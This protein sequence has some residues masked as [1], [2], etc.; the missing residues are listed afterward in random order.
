[1]DGR[2]VTG[3]FALGGAVRLEE[4]EGDPY[5]LLARLRAREPVSWVPALD[6]WLVT[7]HDLAMRVTRDPQTFTVDDPRFSTGQVVGPS[8]L[9]RDGEEH[10]RHRAPFVGPFRR[11]EVHARFAQLVTTQTEQLIDELQPAG[12]AE[13]RRGLAARLAV[14]VVTRALGIEDPDAKAVLR[15]YE[16]IVA[17]VTDLTAGRPI[18]VEGRDAYAALSAA[19]APALERDPD[20][21][22]LAAAAGD[23]GGLERERV[24]SN[25]AVL[26]FGGIETTEGMIANAVWH[27]LLHPDELARVTANHDLLTNAIEESLRLEP[28]AAIVDRYA[29]ADIELAGAPIRCGDLVRV[30][31]TAANRDPELFTDP[32]RFDVT[33]SNARRHLSFAHGPHACIAMH[34]ARL[35]TH[36]ALQRL[37]SRLPT[38][39]LDPARPAKPRGLVFRKPPEL[40]VLWTPQSTSRAGRRV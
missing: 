2:G 20:A 12:R 10:R 19:I 25:A 23:A 7:P 39:R 14:A 15:W 27:L 38:L 31:I 37:L 36:T 34:L 29:T 9:T 5:A 8:M 26:L 22:L 3:R 16:Q 24:I 32:D 1:M 35:E 33:R 17:T 18:G 40:H 6:G 13:L 11:R 30:S 21:S 4:L 28:A